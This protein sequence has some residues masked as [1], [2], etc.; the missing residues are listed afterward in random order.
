MSGW[1][2]KSDS[3]DPYRLERFVA[4]QNP[5]YQQ[6]CAEL[7]QGRKRSHWIWFIFPQIRGLGSSPTA[8]EYAIASRKEA[9]A[10][11]AHPIL[12]PRLEEC[13]GLI[14]QIRGRSIEEIL[15]YPDDLKFRSSMTLFAHATVD[16]RVFLDA[17]QKYF[18]GEFDPLTLERL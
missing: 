16:N 3:D 18:G 4:A 9:A 10:Y 14:T 11:L 17:L 15:L 12:G 5:V 8:V 2:V 7:R 1:H 13:T 6:V